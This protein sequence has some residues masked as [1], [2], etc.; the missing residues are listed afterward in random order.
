MPA[1]ARANAS[2]SLELAHARLCA[3]F[4]ER[5]DE[6]VWR[7]IEVVRDVAG[8]LDI[9]RASSLAPYVTG[10]GPEIE[11]HAL[12]TAARRHWRALVHEVA[13]WMPPPWQPAVRWC[14]VLVDL[15]ALA[16][17]GRREP[18]PAWLA[19]DPLLRG[20]AGSEQALVDRDCSALLRAGGGDAAR[21]QAAWRAQWLARLPEPL[22]AHPLLQRLVHMLDEHAHRFARAHPADAWPLRRGLAARVILLFRRAGDD[23]AQAFAFLTLAALDYERLRGELVPRALLPQRTLAA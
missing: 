20:L 2:G 9:V 13:G 10:I 19:D 17:L 6:A 12:E 14:A 8:V 5:A 21:L 22:P 4:G 3:R 15:P 1:P 16:A 7:R 18:L 23:P 11:A